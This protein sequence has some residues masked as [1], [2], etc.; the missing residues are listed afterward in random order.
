MRDRRV[1]VRN[2]L[3][4]FH[5]QKVACIVA[6]PPTEA[7]LFAEKKMAL[8]SRNDL[9]L[10]IVQ[11]PQITGQVVT[12]NEPANS[13]FQTIRS[14]YYVSESNVVAEN[15]VITAVDVFTVKNSTGNGVSII[16]QRLGDARYSITERL[17]VISGGPQENTITT[18]D[19]FKL[20]FDSVDTSGLGITSA[21][22]FPEFPTA[23]D[24]PLPDTGIYTISTSIQLAAQPL[25]PNV[26]SAYTIE[27]RR[28]AGST[29]DPPDSEIVTAMQIMRN[30]GDPAII[31]TQEGM[32]LFPKLLGS[33]SNQFFVQIVPLNFFSLG[34]VIPIDS[35]S[36]TVRMLASV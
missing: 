20:Q 12:Y 10:P 25:L 36:V 23:V 9:I 34:N 13:V 28:A 11:N 19:P 14:R 31:I 24:I 32:Q 5:G 8:V 35:I 16:D 30:P 4:L 1:R 7:N 27:T 6:R 22:L 15:G 26:I 18:V 3:F 33:D 2:R 17:A 29:P 21:V